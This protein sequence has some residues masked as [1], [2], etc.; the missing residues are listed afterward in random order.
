MAPDIIEVKV[1][2]LYTLFIRFADGVSGEVDVTTLVPF[3]GVF[4][5]LQDLNYFASVKIHPETKT[6]YW[7]NGA[8]ISPCL[9][10]SEVK[11]NP[12]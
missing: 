10:Y 12:K 4:L 9:L 11:K 5:P 1:L 6:I 3:E 8:D 7:D 2:K